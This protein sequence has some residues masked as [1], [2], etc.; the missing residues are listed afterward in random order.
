HVRAQGLALRARLM[1]LQARHPHLVAGVSG[2]GLMQGLRLR[3]DAMWQRP[4]LLGPMHD[5]NILIHLLVSH[6][7]HAGRVRL[8]PS[9]SAGD[10]LRL[11]PALIADASHLEPLGQALEATLDALDRGDTFALARHL[12]AEPGEPAVADLGR[13]AVEAPPAE[14]RRPE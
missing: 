14:L 11:Q 4:G 12:L 6:L 7:L 10:V 13:R 3:F 5:Q 8:A 2:R 9:S 1:A